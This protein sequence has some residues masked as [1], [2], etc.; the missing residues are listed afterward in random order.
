MITVAIFQF[1]QAG[2]TRNVDGRAR[3]HL[4]ITVYLWE[5]NFYQHIM[6]FFSWHIVLCSDALSG[7]P[8]LTPVSSGYRLQI[9]MFCYKLVTENYCQDRRYIY[10]GGIL[11]VEV[12]AEWVFLGENMVIARKDIGLVVFNFILIEFSNN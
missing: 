9:L 1:H 7:C 2:G 6:I 4:E 12:Y 10:V 3:W 8:T 11:R 5:F